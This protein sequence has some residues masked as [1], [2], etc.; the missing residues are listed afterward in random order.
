MG[1]LLIEQSA[2]RL[3]TLFVRLIFG[4]AKIVIDGGVS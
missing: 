3:K 2:R 1:F 4:F